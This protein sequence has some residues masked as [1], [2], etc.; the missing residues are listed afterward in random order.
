[1]KVLN[2]EI[3]LEKFFKNLNNSEKSALLLDYDGTLAPFKVERNKAYPYPGIT[4]ILDD[5]LKFDKCRVVIISGRRAKDII[6][7]LNLKKMPEIW[8]S[9]GWERLV[10]DSKYEVFNMDERIIESLTRADDWMSREGLADRCERKPGCL[11][12]HWRGLEPANV[13]NVREKALRYWQAICSGSGLN[14]HEFNGGVELRAPGRDKG[15][16]VK[17]IISEIG[18]SVLSYMGD[19]FT[20]EDAFKALGDDGLGV[21]IGEKLR[22]TAA[23]LWL[24][25]PEELLDFLKRWADSM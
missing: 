18:N 4:Q 9:H 22:P 19:D 21:F 6:P 15:Y 16:V 17:K 23:D 7:L 14:I 12:I 10:P 2:P 24:K 25:P 20:D 1:M 3:D 5:L 11:A 8:G 13:K